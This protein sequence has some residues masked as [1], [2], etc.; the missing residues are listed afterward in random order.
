MAVSERKMPLY[1][2]IGE[3]VVQGGSL[4]LNHMPEVLNT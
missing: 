2:G 1:F 4:F 3:V